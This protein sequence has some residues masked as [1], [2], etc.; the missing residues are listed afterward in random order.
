MG[1]VSSTCSGLF[2]AS[3]W[4]RA[5]RRSRAISTTPSPSSMRQANEV[6]AEIN[7]SIDKDKAEFEASLKANME[8]TL[9]RQ[10]AASKQALKEMEDSAASRI[11]S[12]INTQAI[13]RGMLEL[14]AMEDS[15]KDKYMAMAIEEL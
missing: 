9:S 4:P 10:E 3:R 11:E 7:A 13:E 15:K 1:P 2:S 14:K 6:I 12:Y 8:S 5:R